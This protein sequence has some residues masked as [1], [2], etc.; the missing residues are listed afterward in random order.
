M[1]KRFFLISGIL[2]LISFYS[3]IQ[4]KPLPP[5]F[6]ETKPTIVVKKSCPLFK[7]NLPSNP[8]TGFSWSMVKYNDHL[9]EKISNQFYPVSASDA[10]LL[11]A[12]GYETWS[13]RVKPTGFIKKQKTTIIFSYQQPWEN[14]NNAQLKKFEVI[15]DNAN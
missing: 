8:T 7:I 11:G 12:P 15:I 2:W 10:S 14:R 4:A 6:N 3:Q 9:I 13:F 5:S 1:L